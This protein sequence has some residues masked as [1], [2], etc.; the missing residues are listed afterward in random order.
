MKKTDEEK[1]FQDDILETALFWV[2]ILCFFAITLLMVHCEELADR[3]FW[4]LILWAGF[5]LNKWFKQAV[6]RFKSSSVEDDE[7]IV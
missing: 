2:P 7:D 1:E 5:I 6:E 4:M 3:L